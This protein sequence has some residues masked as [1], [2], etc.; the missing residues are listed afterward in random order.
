MTVILFADNINQ[1]IVRFSG[2]RPVYKNEPNYTSSKSIQEEYPQLKPIA[3]ITGID[4]KV[5]G[6]ST[7]ELKQYKFNEWKKKFVKKGSK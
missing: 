5:S 2:N 6:M 3:K 4:V 7:K 1:V